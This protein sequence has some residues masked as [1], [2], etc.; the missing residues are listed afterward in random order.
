MGEILSRKLYKRMTDQRVTDISGTTTWEVYVEF[1]S[2]PQ[3][4]LFNLLKI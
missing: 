4:Y 3:N 2:N 1:R